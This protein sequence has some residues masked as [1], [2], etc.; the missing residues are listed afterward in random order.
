M[1]YKNSYI[2]SL[3][4]NSTTF[5]VKSH[6]HERIKQ[7]QNSIKVGSLQ[8]YILSMVSAQ[9]GSVIF[10]A[11][12]LPIEAYMCCKGSFVS[13]AL[14]DLS[15]GPNRQM[16]NEQPFGLEEPNEQQFGLEESN[17][18]QFGLEE[19]NEQETE[20]PEESKGQKTQ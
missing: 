3:K 19:P 9:G 4:I 17:E 1:L 18:Q 15:E 13:N 12:L 7:N 8:I 6:C 11:T 2:P 14:N 5:T 10:L 20:G 16:P